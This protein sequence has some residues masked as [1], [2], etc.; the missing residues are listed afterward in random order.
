[1]NIENNGTVVANGGKLV[2]IA[3]CYEELDCLPQVSVEEV[4]LGTREEAEKVARN[5]DPADLPKKRHCSICGEVMEIATKRE[6]RKQF[7]GN[8]CKQAGFYVSK[9]IGEGEFGEDGIFRFSNKGQM[10]GGEIEKLADDQ[11]RLV[12]QGKQN[13]NEHRYCS[14]VKLVDKGHGDLCFDKERDIRVEKCE[15]SKNALDQH[16]SK[17]ILKKFFAH[18]EG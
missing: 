7:C 2:F 15:E 4:I 1:M 11:F 13:D 5:I 18:N 3:V 8:N 6:A 10:A 14:I 9:K 12:L 16:R 17:F